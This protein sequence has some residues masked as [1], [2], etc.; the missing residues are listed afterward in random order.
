MLDMPESDRRPAPGRQ[1]QA[2]ARPR[3]TG[4]AQES[5]IGHL[6]RAAVRRQRALRPSAGGHHAQLH[7][8]RTPQGS[9]QG[10]R[11]GIRASSPWAMDA[12]GAHAEAWRAVVVDPGRQAVP[13]FAIVWRGD[14]GGSAQQRPPRSVQPCKPQ[15]CA[16]SITRLTRWCDVFIRGLPMCFDPRFDARSPRS[17]LVW[18]SQIASMLPVYSCSRVQTPGSAVLESRAVVSAVRRSPEQARPRK[19]TL[20]MLGPT[21][22]GKSATL[23]YLCMLMMAI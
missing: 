7:D 23:N 14:V 10:A 11:A 16:S 8:H 13:F 12:G 21:G 6:Q 15:G 1:W 22:S 4:S 19:R 17:R 3:S 18:A 2:D 20:L 5:A 9:D